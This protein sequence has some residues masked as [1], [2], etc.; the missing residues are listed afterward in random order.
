MILM[1]DCLILDDTAVWTIL[2]AVSKAAYLIMYA[3]LGVDAQRRSIRPDWSG[4][5]VTPTYV[6]GKVEGAAW[7]GHV[8]GHRWEP[9]II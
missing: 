4:S 1:H 2:Q 8:A 5:L 9:P 3:R 6:F 7:D